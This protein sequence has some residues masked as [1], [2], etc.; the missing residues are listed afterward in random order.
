MEGVVLREMPNRQCNLAPVLDDPQHLAKRTNRSGKKHDAK[1][2][3][4][5]VKAAGFSGPELSVCYGKGSA[6]KFSSLRF[7]TSRF[8]HPRNRIY[9]QDFALSANELGNRQGRFPG[10]CS[11]VEHTAAASNLCG[12]DERLSDR[13]KHLPD[14]SAVLFPIGSCFAPPANYFLHKRVVPTA[15][16]FFDL[17]RGPE[18]HHGQD[19]LRDA[20]PND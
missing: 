15:G 16:P 3:H 8:H 4:H 19:S 7:S 18:H 10:A 11:Y 13:R 9:A 6:V 17:R 12:L 14:N 5:R 2:A 20:S 1:A